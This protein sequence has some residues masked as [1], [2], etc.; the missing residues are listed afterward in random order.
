MSGQYVSVVLGDG[1]VETTPNAHRVI[2]E[3]A[4]LGLVKNELW[5]ALNAMEA[6]QRYIAPEIKIAAM[7][8]AAVHPQGIHF[9]KQAPVLALWSQSGDFHKPDVRAV[10]A[11]SIARM[12]NKHDRLRDLM[13]ALGIARQLRAV[14]AEEWNSGHRA[15]VKKF[16]LLSP[17]TLA[18]IMP[19]WSREKA[20]NIVAHYVG[21]CRSRGADPDRHF[22]WVVRNV[23]ASDFAEFLD[24]PIVFDFMIAAPDRFNTQWGAKRAYE[25]AEKWHDDLSR[26]TEL[27]RA[28]KR[29][30]ATC[31]VHIDISPMPT[32]YNKHGYEIRA[33]TSAADLFEDGRVMRHCVFS[34]WDQVKARNSLIYSVSK[35]GARVATFELM[36]TGK[37]ARTGKPTR[38]WAPSQ[39]R[40]LR[41]AAPTTEVREVVNEFLAQIGKVSVYQDAV[42]DSSSWTGIARSDAEP[43]V[44]QHIDL[45]EGRFDRS[46]TIRQCRQ[47][48]W[49]F[50]RGGSS[51]RRRVGSD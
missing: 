39:I 6:E 41:N 30:G 37:A 13:D 48:S 23:F 31:D 10:K 50:R 38:L 4:K 24:F 27:E 46:M 5:V 19:A 1:V 12:L 2:V 40:G 32:G 34:Y 35:G 7:I 28:K 14:G 3:L 18:Q 21:I 25:E 26:A 9:L 8:F 29:M 36:A 33:L 22:E 47:L 20:L 43:V 45:V 11:R 16:K 49:R 51:R 15:I 44:I 42:I 17:S